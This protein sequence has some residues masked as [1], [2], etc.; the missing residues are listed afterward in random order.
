MFCQQRHWLDMDITNIDINCEVAAEHEM[1]LDKCVH[2]FF[3]VLGAALSEYSCPW[4]WTIVFLACWNLSYFISSTM[5]PSLNILTLLAAL[6]CNPWISICPKFIL[7][8]SGSLPSLVFE[9]MEKVYPLI[10]Y[11]HG[12][13]FDSGFEKV[14]HS[15]CILYIV[16]SKSCQRKI[17]A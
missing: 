7:R 10:C 4:F 6:I 15:S 16:I 1:F 8:W 5:I 17:C 2:A 13:G 3:A 11:I 9:T 12:E 14:G